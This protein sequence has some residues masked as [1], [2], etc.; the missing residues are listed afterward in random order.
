MCRGLIRHSFVLLAVATAV[1]ARPAAA[2]TISLTPSDLKRWDVSAGVGWVAGNKSG[3]V[4]RWNDWYDTFAVSL[5]VGRY[6]TPHLKTEVSGT[7]TTSGTVYSGEQVTV[8]G[9]P[10]PIF[11]SREH[12]FR[13]DAVSA[14][15]SYQF[16]D[17]AWVH[18]FLTAGVQAAREHERSVRPYPVAFDGSGRPFGVTETVREATAVAVRPFAGG[19]FKF[20][21]SERVFVRSDFTAAVASGRVAQTAWRGGVGVDF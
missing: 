19:G 4:E 5:D 20:Y 9:V 3:T 11:V 15:V 8:P 17:N 1:A 13:L 10:H 21:V 7:F 16:L 6:W 2:Q 12:R 18:P 14:S